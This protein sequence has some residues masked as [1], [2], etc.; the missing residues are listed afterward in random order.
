M[1]SKS[2]IVLTTLAGAAATLVLASGPHTSVS[3]TVQPTVLDGGGARSVSASYAHQGSL[4]GISGTSAAGPYATGHGYIAQLTGDCPAFAAWQIVHFG[5]TSHPNAG[6]ALDPDND[7]ADNLAEFAFNLNPNTP[8][9]STMPPGGSAGLPRYAVEF[10]EAS[11]RLTVE[12]VHRTG[13]GTYLVE[14][15]GNLVDWKEAGTIP[16]AIPVPLPGGFER[17]KLADGE[18]F[19]A[20]SR[21][22]L[23]VKV[24]M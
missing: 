14:A 7:G 16:V 11:E 1:K 24:E 13:C 18:V 6:P 4:D 17:V 8:D 12:F 5:S 2:L 10:V 3:Y 23:R 19:G 15:S 22:Y 9:A 20:R 21:R